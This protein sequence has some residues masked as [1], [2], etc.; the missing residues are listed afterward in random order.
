MA[1]YSQKL[2]LEPKYLG[3]N[4]PNIQY[5]TLSHQ[6]FIKN[7]YPIWFIGLILTFSLKIVQI[8]AVY[9]E[10][11]VPQPRYLGPSSSNTQ[12]LTSSDH[13]FFKN[14]YFMWSELSI[15]LS[16]L[17]RRCAISHLHESKLGQNCLTKIGARPDKTSNKLLLGLIILA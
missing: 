15:S 5:L 11:L 4:M 17:D 9:S 8:F 3:P 6:E 7:I 2:V 10:Y 13:E 1:F 16:V 12:Y 14:I